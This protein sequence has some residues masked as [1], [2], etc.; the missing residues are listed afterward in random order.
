MTD[1][2]TLQRLKAICDDQGGSGTIEVL[3]IISFDV[4]PSPEIE[5]IYRSAYSEWV[6][7]TELIPCVEPGC[8]FD[9]IEITTYELVEYDDSVVIRVLVCPVEYNYRY[10]I[11]GDLIGQ[12][13]L[14]GGACV[15]RTRTG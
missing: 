9:F 10:Y 6:A 2:N 1:W 5:R 15:W 4:Q 3:Q 11:D 8:D 12:T 13:V 7:R 14:G